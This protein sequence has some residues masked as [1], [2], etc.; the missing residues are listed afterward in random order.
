VGLTPGLTERGSAA[1][2][3]GWV[4][5]TLASGAVALGLAAATLVVLTPGLAEAQS[6]EAWSVVSARMTADLTAGDGSADV[7]IRYV[8]SGTPRGA[9]LPVERPVRLELLGFGGATVSAFTVDG[10]QP[11][12]MWPTS[13][14]HRAA[15]IAVSSEAGR[16]GVVGVELAYRVD[17]AVERADETLRARVPLLSGPSSPEQGVDGG[18]EARISFPPEWRLSEAFPS[19]LQAVEPGVWAGTLPVVPALVGFRGRSDGS[20]RPGFPLVADLVMLALLGA[21]TWFGWRHLRGVSK[22]ANAPAHDAG[23]SA[24][25]ATRAT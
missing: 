20:W 24:H 21:F 6:D 3:L 19:G 23:T 13:G 22:R 1:A 5:A 15:A 14:S 11:V 2:A 9:P 17:G 4:A 18:F 7:R 16:G 10:G 8:L 25:D 12:V